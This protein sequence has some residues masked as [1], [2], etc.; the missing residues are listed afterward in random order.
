L[1]VETLTA[2][3]LAIAKQLIEFETPSSVSNVA[4]TH[5]IQQRLEA[6]GFATEITEYVDQ[7]GVDQSVGRG[8]EK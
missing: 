4:V 5:F 2:A 6:V 3:A 7:S 1:G 8:Q